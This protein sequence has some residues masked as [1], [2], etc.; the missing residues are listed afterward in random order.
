VAVEPI[1]ETFVRIRPDLGDL[2]RL[3][4]LLKDLGEALTRYRECCELDDQQRTEGR[5]S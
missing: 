2:A 5:E 3:E 1:A 4:A